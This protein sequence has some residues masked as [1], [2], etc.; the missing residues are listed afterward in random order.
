MP[1][2]Y[3]GATKTHMSV[4]MKIK[5]SLNTY[6]ALNIFIFSVLMKIKIFL[7][8]YNAL[9]IFVFSID[10]VHSENVV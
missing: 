8:T 1:I 4:L 10:S 9:N 3:D 6:N 5:I 2:T 7:N